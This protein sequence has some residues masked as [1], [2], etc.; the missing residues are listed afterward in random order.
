MVVLFGG[1]SFLLVTLRCCSQLPPQGGGNQGL[2]RQERACLLPCSLLVE[3]SAPGLGGG[4]QVHV[5]THPQCLL[6]EAMARDWVCSRSG[7]CSPSLYK[8][9]GVQL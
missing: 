5:I 7:S 4:F 3:G 8:T 1:W 2:G 6:Q 9:V